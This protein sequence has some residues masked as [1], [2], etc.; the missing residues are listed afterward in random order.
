[1]SRLALVLVLL[2]PAS[3]TAQ[4]A[5]SGVP[6]TATPRP[7]VRPGDRVR[8][9]PRA[10]GLEPTVG[11][12]LGAADGQ[13]RLE[14]PGNGATPDTILVPLESLALLERSTGQGRKTGSGAAVGALV[15]LMAGVAAGFAS[16]DDPPSIVSFSAG[17]KAMAGG[18]AG[19][20]LGAILGAIIGSTQV[21]DRW[22]VVPLVPAGTGGGPGLALRLELGR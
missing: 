4:E 1:M 12:W 20:G 14:V 18:L 16:G 7:V 8:L 17:E 9:H 6:W 21:S 15:G 2:G 13:A 19:A 5:P 10:E 3:L 22:Q 11:R